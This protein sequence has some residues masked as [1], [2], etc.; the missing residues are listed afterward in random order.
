MS[1]SVSEA[2]SP[3]TAQAVAKN[4]EDAIYARVT[5][6]LLPLLVICYAVS[7]LD[8]VNVSFAKLQMAADLHLSDTVYGFGAGIFFIGYVLAEVPSNLLLH[9][10]GAR[11][12]IARIL[13]TWGLLSAAMIYVSSPISFYCLRFLL[14]VA[15]AGFLPGVLYYLMQWYP[16]TRRGSITSKLYIGSALSGVIGGPLSGLILSRFGGV[17]GLAGWQWMFLIEALPAVAL[18]VIVF[19]TLNDRIADAKWLSD[20]EKAI[21]EHNVTFEEKGKDHIPVSAV[22]RSRHVWFLSAVLFLLVMGQYGIYFWMP[23][24][25]KESGVHDTLLIGLMTAIPYAVAIVV[26]TLV[27]RMSDRRG[28]RRFYLFTFAIIGAAALVGAVS[29]STRPEVVL[30]ALTVSTAASMT[31]LPIFWTFPPA[32]LKGRA[33]AAGIALVNSL[34]VTAG[35][36]APYMI[37]ALRDLTGKPASGMYVLAACWLTASVLGLKLRSD[38]HG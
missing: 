33:A 15:E 37:G 24:M 29:V 14:G 31:M 12:W 28:D 25:V 1:Y 13:I 20:E 5:R 32:V 17:S 7:Y 10:V 21:L 23:T 26:M 6:R 4:V 22:F 3:S 9:R 38:K 30:L 18:G 2:G 8:R 27:G 34:G 19:F 11:R 36:V 35:F 16:S